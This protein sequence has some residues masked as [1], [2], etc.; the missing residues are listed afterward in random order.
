[1]PRNK[2]THKQK[3]KDKGNKTTQNKT[4]PPKIKK[5]IAKPVA[6]EKSSESFSP[7]VEETCLI[8]QE[9]ISQGLYMHACVL[10]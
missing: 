2:N 8:P 9:E 10:V 3:K 1:M 7:S 6:V 5:V 4:A